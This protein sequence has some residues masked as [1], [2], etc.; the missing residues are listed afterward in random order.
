V[1]GVLL[2]GGRVVIPV[3]M[4]T[5]IL[6]LIHEVH[7]GVGKGKRRTREAV[8]WPGINEVIKQQTGNSACQTIPI[9]TE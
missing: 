1:D 7:L 2:S 6:V 8:Y 4:R 3:T 9:P 5:E